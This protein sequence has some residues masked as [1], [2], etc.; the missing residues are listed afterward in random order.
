MAGDV[1]E[2]RLPPRVDDRPI[3]VVSSAAVLTA[4]ARR[5]GVL[6]VSD[7]EVNVFVY[8]S[9]DIQY[10]GKLNLVTGSYETSMAALLEDAVPKPTAQRAQA[11]RRNALKRLHQQM[12]RPVRKKT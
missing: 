2:N 10:T 9:G 4:H 8:K 7:V 12:I 1:H 11:Q 5:F 6:E 3:E